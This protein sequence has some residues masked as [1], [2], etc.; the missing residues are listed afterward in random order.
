MI[1]KFLFI[2]LISA[3]LS[4]SIF[5]QARQQVA[6]VVHD[7]L[8]INSAILGEERTVLVRVPANYA[9]TSEKFPVVYM[10]DAHPPQ[11]AMMAGI[12]EQQVWGDMMPEM[13][14]VGI[15]N[16]NRTRDLT[17]TKN[18]RGEGGG[19]DKFLQFIESEV[20]PLVEKNYRTQP[21]RI[22]AGHSL[23]GLFAVYSFV[24]R[25]DLFNAYIAASPVLQWDDNLVIKRA[26]EIFRQKKEF[27]KVMFL[28]LGNEQ[29]LSK[30]FGAFRD[31]LKRA[32]PKGF[33]YEMREMP[34]ENH[35][36]VVLPAYYWGLRKIYAGWN[37][38]SPPRG[39]VPD[40]IVADL[41]NHY[42]KLTKR[43]GYEIP[44]P[45]N[46]LNQVGYFFLRGN[47]LT[48]AIET[49]RK[50][51]VNHPNS[52]NVYDSLAEAYE[53]NGQLKLAGENYEKAYKM[54]EARGEARLAKTAK[55]NFD[56]ISNKMK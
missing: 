38:P 49:F 20:I 5:A 10:T 19:A 6:S 43:F 39:T 44:V 16:T 35:G 7:R 42:K 33:E 14:L 37:P 41:E 30:G 23:G 54:A 17:L 36:S 8:T 24:A 21:Y 34:E 50:N 47:R 13:I 32:D 15:Q 3:I 40:T 9:Q 51:S 29:D 18:E 55:E 46:T 26:E 4:V 48:E 28:A 12:I 1:R 2:A 11:N 45:E 22:F 56:R 25:P 27:K 31:L 52:A 53:K